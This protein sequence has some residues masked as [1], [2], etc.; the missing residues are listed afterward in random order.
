MRR[1]LFVFLFVFCNFVL[2]N[3]ALA[4]TVLVCGSYT[5]AGGGFV[6][7][8]R[9]FDLPGD[10]DCSNVLNNYPDQTCTNRSI[11]SD[12]W[13]P[14]AE[15]VVDSGPFT[16]SAELERVSDISILVKPSQLSVLELIAVRDVDM[17]GARL[18]GAPDFDEANVLM[19]GVL[20]PDETQLENFL[21]D[22]AIDVEP[23]PLE[24]D[25]GIAY[26]VLDPDTYAVLTLQ[27]EPVIVSELEFTIPEPSQLILVIVGMVFQSSFRTKKQNRN[28]TGG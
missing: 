3:T 21:G 4:K 19:I 28:L 13:D 22:S 9:Y 27:I 24:A 8:C 25:F 16:G 10:K 2:S 6:Y 14:N 17:R 7:S 20:L 15:G 26:A 18:P 11:V 1:I 5:N 12:G 23:L